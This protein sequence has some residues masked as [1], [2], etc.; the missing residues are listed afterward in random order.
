MSF[1]TS[2]NRSPTG[3]EPEKA[4]TDLRPPPPNTRADQLLDSR[5]RER[6]FRGGSTQD[7]DRTGIEAEYA[8]SKVR[9]LLGPQIACEY[10]YECSPTGIEPEHDW[11]FM[12]AAR[13]TKI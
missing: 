9:I 6:E 1:T 7:D 3:I 12:V 2:P 10:W 13:R 5:I 4:P 8:W 11:T